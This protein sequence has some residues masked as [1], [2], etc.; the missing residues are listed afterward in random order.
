MKKLEK[1][2][3]VLRFGYRTADGL[4]V[5]LFINALTGEKILD[6]RKNK[7]I[8]RPQY[9]VMEGEA[10]DFGSLREFFKLKGE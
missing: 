6:E 3:K 7:R 5:G 8:D 1:T 10:Q 9:A 4:G 2:T